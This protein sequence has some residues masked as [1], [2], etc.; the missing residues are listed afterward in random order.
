MSLADA[1]LRDILDN[2][3]DDVPRLVFADWLDDH[4]DPDRA[5]F[6]RVQCALPHLPV[7]DDRRWE[8]MARERHLI[9]RHGKGW[10][11]P[12]RW[13]VKRWQFRRGFV[14]GVALRAAD[15]LRHAEQLFRLS[16]ISH[17][18]LYDADDV[19]ELLAESAYLKKVRGLDLRHHPRLDAERLRPL[20]W[21]P[22]LKGLRALGLRGTRLCN[23]AGFRALAACPNLAGVAELDLGDPLEPALGPRPRYDDYPALGEWYRRRAEARITTAGVRALAESPHLTALRSLAL[24]GDA[25]NFAPEAIDDFLDSP[26]LGRLTALDLRTRFPG[27]RPGLFG[28]LAR[29]E[30]AR[31]L[32]TLRLTLGGDAPPPQG[33]QGPADN[34]TQLTSLELDRE[35]LDLVR[36]RDFLHTP[37]PNLTTLRLFRC[38]LLDDVLVAVA[39]GSFLPKL[40]VLCLDETYFESESTIPAE[41]KHLGSVCARTLA[42]SPGLGRLRSLTVNGAGPPSTRF[43]DAGAVLLAE[44]PA[45][46]RLAHLDL[47]NH[48]IQDRGLEALARSPHLSG[49]RSLHLAHNQIGW[50]GVLALSDR[51]ALPALAWLDLRDNPLP[52]SSRDLLR[53]RFGPGARYGPAPRLDPPPP[54]VWRPPAPL[55]GG[56]MIDDIPF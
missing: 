30:Q 37:L 35:G 26:L 28:R 5:E 9:L 53:E 48:G 29:S 32:R 20:L 39:D 6:I 45:A 34:L 47:N 22:R 12:L 43:R 50:N 14:G 54:D 2:P 36:A 3:D 49:L 44:A 55:P 52:P 10:A 7:E 15:F 25:T 42:E 13:L 33:E 24:E 27:Q 11:G 38:Q 23:D 31:G 46:A 56:P 18:R 8:L 16:P 40:R 4:G 17:V 19:V 51:D 41:R 1:F 21:S